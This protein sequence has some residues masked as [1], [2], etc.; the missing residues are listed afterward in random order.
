MELFHFYQQCSM[1]LFFINMCGARKV[2]LKVRLTSGNTLGNL[3]RN[4]R[5]S[6]KQA[7]SGLGYSLKN[8]LHLMHIQFQAPT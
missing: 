1:K 3:F 8:S 2:A 4:E 7:V 6:M 5:F